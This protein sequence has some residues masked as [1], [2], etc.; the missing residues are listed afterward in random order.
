[1]EAHEAIAA[2][3]VVF[4]RTAR[5]IEFLVGEQID[6]RTGEQTVRLPK[7]HVDPGETIEEAALREVTEESGRK[8]RGAAPLG[9]H[10]Y[11]FVAPPRRERPGGLIEKRVVFFLMEDA[12]QS[13]APRDAEMERVLWLDADAAC[14]RL[15]FENEQAML[16][17]AAELLDAG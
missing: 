14:Q 12:G 3:G 4:R 10:R 9:E 6:W 8:V 11:S 13:D 15:T 2:G 5:G 16:R 1:L 17:R 7:G